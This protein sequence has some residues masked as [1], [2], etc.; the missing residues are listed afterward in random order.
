MAIPAVRNM[1]SGATR[2]M[3][4]PSHSTCPESHCGQ[5]VDRFEHCGLSCSIGSD[6]ADDLAL[7]HFQVDIADNVMAWVISG[8]HVAQFEQ[9]SFDGYLG[10]S[11][12]APK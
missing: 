3:S 1:S 7:G 10:S 2:V 9:R 8:A 5:A 12:S 6:N 4:C 11:P